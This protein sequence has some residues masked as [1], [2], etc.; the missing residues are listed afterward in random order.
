MTTP[1]FG[2]LIARLIT[3]DPLTPALLSSGLLV[4]LGIGI[5]TWRVRGTSP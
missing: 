5:T 2:L 3:G 1:I 4:A